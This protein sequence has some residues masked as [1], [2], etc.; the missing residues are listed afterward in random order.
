[1]A[2][3]SPWQLPVPYLFG[4][5]EAMLGLVAFT[6]LILACS[7]WKLSSGGST[8][9]P[10]IMAGDKQPMFLVKPVTSR[11]AEVELAAAAAPPSTT[12]MGRRRKWTSNAA[13]VEFVG[14]VHHRI[15]Y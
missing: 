11:A 14:I 7:Y 9:W 10:V 15:C 12:S 13:R 5:L 2:P 4:G 3:H 8:W 1:M 6:L